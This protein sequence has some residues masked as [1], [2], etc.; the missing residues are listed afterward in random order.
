[1]NKTLKMALELADREAKA[2]RNVM[3]L[4]PDTSWMWGMCGVCTFAPSGPRGAIYI[5]CSTCHSG[6]KSVAID[7]LILVASTVP[8]WDAAGEAFA[9]ERLRTSLDPRVIQVKE[10]P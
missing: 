4:V 9:R 1:M 5:R 2:G 6:L 7:T 3:I 10:T 8:T